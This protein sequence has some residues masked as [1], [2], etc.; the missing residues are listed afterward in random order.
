VNDAA[1][2]VGIAGA[3]LMGRWHARAAVRAGGRVLGVADPDPTCARRL[4]AAHPGARAFPDTGAMLAALRLWALHVCSP[5][6]THATLAE[7]ALERGLHVLVE[8]P[9][10]EDAATTERLVAQAE[11]AGR[12][13]VP[14]HQYP[15]Q[16]GF[17]RAREGLARVGPLRHAEMT[18]C[19]AGGA[20]RDE[21][22]LAEL[23]AEILPHPL[24]VAQALLGSRIG[25]L[26]WSAERFA[27]GEVLVQARDGALA[28]RALVSAASRPPESSL[29]LRGEG[30]TWRVDFFHGYASFE[31]GSVGRPAK[32]LRPFG[33]ST[34]ELLAASSNLV[35][36]AA[37]HE[38]AYPGLRKLVAAFYR[39]ASGE[40]RPPIG[41][42]AV[43]DLALVRDRLL[44]ELA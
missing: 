15:F 13:L 8:K 7:N 3:G 34:R 17:S 14:V 40:G 20:G 35:R 43:R 1:L 18:L 39:A 28:F 33:R 19:T 6:A 25:E 12:L 42:A 44:A 5:L 37:A 29:T 30:G 24:S 11:R 31:P 26:A 27:P 41:L 4:A 16:R 32:I 21:R 22:G 36:R 2:P 23:V 9:L 38:S 10:A